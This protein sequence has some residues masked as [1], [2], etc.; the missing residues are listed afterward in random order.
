MAA[1]SIPQIGDTIQEKP[2]LSEIERGSEKGTNVPREEWQEPE[3]K[4]NWQM[5]MACLVGIHLL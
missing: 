3:P 5:A 4:I 2:Q 1:E